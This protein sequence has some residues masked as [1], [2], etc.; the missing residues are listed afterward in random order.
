MGKNVSQTSL[1]QA[2][3]VRPLIVGNWKM[4]GVKSALAEAIKVKDGLPKA[5][6]A[7]VIIC[8]PATLIMVL[9][10]VMKGSRVQVGGQDCHAATS[11]AF[12]GDLA[13]PMLRDGGATAVILGHSE[14]RALHGERD[15]DVRA[16]VQAAHASGL[17]AIVCVGETAGE[18]AS[19]LTDTV[20]CR[21]LLGSLPAN[22]TAANTVI[23]YE[24]VWAIGTGLTATPA[25]VAA[26]HARIV[27]MVAETYGP[28]AAGMRVLYG[29]SV[30]AANAADLMAVANVHGALVGGA[31]LLAADFMGIISACDLTP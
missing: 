8:P 7:D 3:A 4:N 21:Q 1:K 27:A 30:K 13:A 26:V 25:D 24:P 14:R 22:I 29:G 28:A 2:E 9:S 17:I 5:G 12:T 23:A 6:R 15:C 19:G 16:K 18:R 31:S 20:V 10:E 11:G